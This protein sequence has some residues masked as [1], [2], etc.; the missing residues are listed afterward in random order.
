[1]ISNI[2]LVRTRGGIFLRLG[3]R[4]RPYLAS[5]SGASSDMPQPGPGMTRPGVGQLRKVHIAQIQGDGCDAVGCALSGLPGH[6]LENIHLQGIRLEF[7]GDGTRADAQRPIPEVETAYPEYGMFGRLPAYGFY[8]RHVRGLTLDGVEVAT[9]SADERPAL[10]CDDVENLEVSAWRGTGSPDAPEIVLRNVRDAFLHGC[11][12]GPAA[13]SFVRV[14]GNAS[15][16]ICVA[17]TARPQG[18]PVLDRAPE[19]AP[20]AVHLS[21]P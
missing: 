21:P 2:R 13:A 16:D 18:P 3:N 8:S 15:R 1:M 19:V 17:A 9:V 20:E 6:P 11:R 12:P 7:A 5:E 4:A 14:E 10:V